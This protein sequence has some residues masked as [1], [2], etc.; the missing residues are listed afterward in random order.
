MDVDMI[1][2]KN[3]NNPLTTK[4]SVQM[5]SVPIE[6]VG[7]DGVGRV[8]ARSVTA[9]TVEGVSKPISVARVSTKKRVEASE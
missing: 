6:Q 7:S 5:E 2:E 3:Q 4:T 9:A 1:Q 8:Y